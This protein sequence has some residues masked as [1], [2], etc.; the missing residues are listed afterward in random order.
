MRVQ[1]ISEKP[2]ARVAVLDPS[3]LRF[4]YDDKPPRWEQ[5]PA[6]K[7]N[8]PRSESV[9]PWGPAYTHNEEL[10]RALL[11]ECVAAAPLGSAP[12]TLY[13]SLWDGL[14]R[15]N[16]W[17]DYCHPHYGDE[18]DYRDWWRGPGLRPWE[19]VISLSGKRIEIHPAVTRYVVAHEYGHLVDTAL[20]Q[21]RWPGD[22]NAFHKLHEDY[23][24][25]RRL[26]TVS[27]YGNGTHHLD[28]GEVLAND[29]R[30]IAVERERDFWA[31]PVT[32]GWKLKRVV[33]WWERAL[34]DLR[35]LSESATT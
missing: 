33:A 29:F 11:R 28:V 31:H 10:T 27:H 20:A 16:G 7:A 34:A 35:A 14:A 4:G 17:S 24:R 12:V 21:L 30:T 9:D 1:T 15:M 2:L 6:L 3:D 32:P 25:L 22:P 19:G 8:Y 26:D 18:A 5:Q 23:R 13:L